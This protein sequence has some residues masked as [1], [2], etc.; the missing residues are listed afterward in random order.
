MMIKCVI[1]ISG[2]KD[3]Q[4][5]LVLALNHFYKDEILGLFCDTRWEHP[6]T[7]DHI[8]KMKLKYGVQ[9]KTL[10]A[11]SVP[12]EILRW[13][14]FPNI[15]RFCTDYLKIQPSKNYYKWLA[16][17]QG[18]GF[19]VWYGMRSDESPERD[20][21][22]RGI[23]DSEL[24]PPHEVLKSKYPKYL[25]DKLGVTFR[26]PIIDWCRSEVLEVLHGFYNPLYDEGFDRVG[27]SPC[28]ASG[29]KWK[30]KAFAHDE[31]GAGQK[32]IMMQVEKEIGK[33]M[34]NSKGGKARN[35]AI[36]S[37]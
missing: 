37:I 6:K 20:K 28:M 31:F 34:W 7:Y 10:N 36:C 27:C 32:V 35:C 8:E 12:G 5:C 24:Y 9:I 30:E 16:E 33:S 25:Y 18:E 17:H 26:L 22:Y 15:A 4:A 3:S 19:Q 23:I 11:G 21:R 29:D 14:R 2:G 13:K 1:P